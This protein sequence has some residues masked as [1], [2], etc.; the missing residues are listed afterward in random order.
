M[1]FFLE[2][3]GTIAFAFAGALVAI[4]NDLDLFGIEC[5]AVMTACGGG[6]TRDLLLG[7]T[8]PMMFRNPVYVLSAV[9]TAF[10]TFVIYHKFVQS[11]FK[12]KILDIVNVL[13]AIGLAIF[14]TVAMDLA[15]QLGHESGFLICAV[16]VITAVGGGLLRDM[17]C[18]VKPAVLTKDIYATA[19]M[20]GAVAY[21]FMLK[22]AIPA[23][24]SN[25]IALV[26]IFG[27]RMW[28][29]V[30][31]VNLPTIDKAKHNK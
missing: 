28:A 20:V 26:L 14:T 25:F 19:S 11:R 6:M 24:V 27:M 31:N 18:N 22:T 2:V 15:I 17:M 4:D 16:G 1:T 10:L 8:P 3:I 21:F 13:D 23:V 7:N 9:A 30:H 29:I 5:M 12:D